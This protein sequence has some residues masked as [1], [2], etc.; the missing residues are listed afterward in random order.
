MSTNLRLGD[1]LAAAL[2][3][4]AVQRGQS[5][6]EIVREA[7]AKELGLAPAPTPMARAIQS[8]LIKPPTPYREVVAAV[9]LPKGTTTL[10]L[11]DRDDR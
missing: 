8:G 2:R 7:I 9:R 6:Q 3:H 5:Q 10:D 4:A 11:L 1:E